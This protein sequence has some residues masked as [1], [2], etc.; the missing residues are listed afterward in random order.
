MKKISYFQEY[1]HHILSLIMLCSFSVRSEAISAQLNQTQ[2]HLTKISKQISHIKTT[3]SDDMKHHQEI[4][5]KINITETALEKT[6][7]DKLALQ[8]K[9][10]NLNSM[11]KSLKTSIDKNQI[12]IKS[13][14]N[15]IYQHL[16]LQLMLSQEPYWQIVFGAENPFD[17]YQR[18]ELYQYLNDSEQLQFK[19]LNQLKQDFQQKQVSLNENIQQLSQLQITLSEKQRVYVQEKK[20]HQQNLALMNKKITQHTAELHVFEKNQKNIKKLMQTLL[21]ENTLQSRRPFTVMK[22]KL[23]LPIYQTYT[24]TQNIQ[25][26]IMFVAPEN[27][28]VHAVSP[29]KV[30]F[31]DWLN[32]Y[33]YLI[34][35]DHGWGF[36][37]L[38]GN[39]HALLKHRGQYV[40]SGDV[41]ST[42]GK[43]GAFH[44]TGLYFELRQRAKVIAARTWF[45]QKTV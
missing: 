11:I 44:Q 32:G 42:V 14:Q 20:E 9:I 25:N 17:Y 23:S 18:I 3:I 41:L 21:K 4:K 5:K 8:K 36:M 16:K 13:Y 31:A 34:I 35:L 28:A 30:V 40:N 29:G 33:G 38:Y 10:M 37:T 45:K 7:Q 26:G 6:L 24:R 22:Y 43:S 27:T 19:H 15:A 1:I 2:K 39:N 12:Q